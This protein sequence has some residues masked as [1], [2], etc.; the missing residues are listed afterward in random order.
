MSIHKEKFKQLLP[1]LPQQLATFATQTPGKCLVSRNVC[2]LG[3]LVGRG[4]HMHPHLCTSTLPIRSLQNVVL[5]N[6]PWSRRTR[7]QCQSCIMSPKGSQYDTNTSVYNV[8]L[9]EESYH[10]E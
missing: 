4:V 7:D 8:K 2:S 1:Q 9:G 3:D 6:M 10:T 5:P